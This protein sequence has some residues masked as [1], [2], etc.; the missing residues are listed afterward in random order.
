MMQFAARGALAVSP[1]ENIEIMVYLARHN[2]VFGDL[3]RLTLA[4]WDEKASLAAAS[5]ANTAQE[6]LD[7]LIAPENL[8]PKLLPALL[9]NVSVAESEIVKLAR[10]ASPVAI[11]AML[12]SPRVR[13][14]TEVLDSLQ[15][16][17]YLKANELDEVKGLLSPCLLYTSIRSGKA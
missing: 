3:A 7:Y 8:R 12:H 15:S 1:A 2:P 6:V 13:A 14:S 10:S 5:D 4:G 9:E 11:A 16:N 17:P